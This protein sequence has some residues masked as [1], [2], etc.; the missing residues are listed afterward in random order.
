MAAVFSETQ[1]DV[2]LTVVSIERKLE[3]S[4]D[5]R[6]EGAARLAFLLEEIGVAGVSCFSE[7]ERK[8][9]RCRHD[10]SRGGI[11]LLDALGCKPR[12]TAAPVAYSSSA[13]T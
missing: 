6:N 7:T 2:R 3:V 5:V 1:V 10:A 9:F 11:V 12:S 4:N 13:V 8:Y